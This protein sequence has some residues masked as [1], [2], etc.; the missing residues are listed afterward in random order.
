MEGSPPARV[1]VQRADF[2]GEAQIR[3]T[4]SFQ[5]EARFDKLTARACAFGAPPELERLRTA[6]TE[7]QKAKRQTTPSGSAVHPSIEGNEPQRAA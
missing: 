1:A 5:G 3:R 2:Q 7:Q 6:P 4:T